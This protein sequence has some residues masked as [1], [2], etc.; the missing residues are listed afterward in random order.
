MAQPGSAA[1]LGTV[2]RR[3]ESY[4]PD[5]LLIILFLNVAATVSKANSC[6]FFSIIVHLHRKILISIKKICLTLG[7]IEFFFDAI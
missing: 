6:L 1:V 3:F 4:R 7:N 5:H 2:G